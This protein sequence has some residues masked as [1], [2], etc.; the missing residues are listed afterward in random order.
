MVIAASYISS[1]VST[2]TFDE[3]QIKPKSVHSAARCVYNLLIYSSS[4]GVRE[5]EK[6]ESE[7]RSDFWSSMASWL[8]W[9]CSATMAADSGRRTGSGSDG[10]AGIA[11]AAQHFSSA[12]TVKFC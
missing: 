5:R 10:V 3:K 7:A 9:F 2:Q 4:L 11:A 8:S 1:A 12:H 6:M